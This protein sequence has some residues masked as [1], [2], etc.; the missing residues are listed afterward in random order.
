MGYV[1]VGVEYVGQTGR[2]TLRVY[3]DSANGITLEDCEVVSH[4]ISGLLD[5]ENLISGAYDLEVSS[6]GLDRPL[7]RLEDF[8]RFAGQRV[9]IRLA[10]PADGR[11]N[12]AGQLLG[13]ENDFV[14]IEVDGEIFK[15]DYAQI[16]RARL[17]PQY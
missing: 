6:P 14:N 10:I 17:V 13:V 16:E 12:F 11:R 4:Q 2:N 3:I 9:K 15:L 7:F 1:F 8:V 5:V